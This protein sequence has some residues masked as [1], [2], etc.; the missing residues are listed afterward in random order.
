MRLPS[1]PGR[2]AFSGS[3]WGWVKR[4][5][6][7]LGSKLLLNGFPYASAPWHRE[8]LTVDR[9]LGPYSLHPWWRGLFWISGGVQHFWRLELADLSGWWHGSRSTGHPHGLNRTSHLGRYR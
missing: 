5:I 9:R 7:P 2:L 1:V 3:C 6:G 4:E 8:Y